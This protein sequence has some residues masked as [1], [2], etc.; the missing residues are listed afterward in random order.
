MGLGV[1]DDFFGEIE[2]QV[3]VGFDGV[4]VHS[5]LAPA[6]LGEEGLSA[7]AAGEQAVGTS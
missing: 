6:V 3:I 2:D 5:P 1:L 7:V 4:V